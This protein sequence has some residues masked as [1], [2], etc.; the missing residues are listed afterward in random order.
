MPFSCVPFSVRN[1]VAVGGRCIYNA[2]HSS[3]ETGRKHLYV[4]SFPGGEGKWQILGDGGDMP[5]WRRDGKEL[6]YVS[7]SELYAAPVSQ[8]GS[9]FNPGQPHLL[10]RLDNT[11]ATGRVYDAAPDGTRFITPVVI[12]HGGTPTNLLL[13]WPAELA[14]K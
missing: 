7:A 12:N 2:V 8:V 13:N 9:Q 10:F 3:T 14:K 11:I 1:C 4:T 5:A 6:Y